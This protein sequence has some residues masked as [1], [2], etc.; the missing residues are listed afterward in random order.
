MATHKEINTDI[1]HY[2]IHYLSYSLQD[3]DLA[4]I[5]LIGKSKE[6][7]YIHFVKDA[8]Q[9]PNNQL[10]KN[11]KMN[12]YYPISRFGDVINILQKVKKPHMQLGITDIGNLNTDWLPVGVVP[13]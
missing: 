3:G 4:G 5:I 8:P 12:I 9:M 7:G 2:V 11:G 1:D 6:I 13:A 10:D